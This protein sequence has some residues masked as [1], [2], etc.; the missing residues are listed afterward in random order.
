[1]KKPEVS[2][3]EHLDAK[4]TLRAMEKQAQLW[5]IAEGRLGWRLGVA[6]LPPVLLIAIGLT[7]LIQDAGLAGLM[8][9]APGAVY[10]VLGVALLVSFLWSASQRQLNALLEIVRRLESD[11]R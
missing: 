6:L 2:I 3:A 11:R 4:L 9:K 1:M 5:R 8:R 7:Q 10:V